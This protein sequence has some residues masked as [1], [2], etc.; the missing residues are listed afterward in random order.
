MDDTTTAERLHG[1]T[2]AALRDQP[3]VFRADLL[4][5]RRILVTGAG[6]GL[7]KAI[8]TLCARLGADLAICGRDRGRLDASAAFLEQFGTRIL[9]RLVSIR[10]PDAV[11]NFLDEAW[12]ALGPLDGVV[13]NAGGQFP[14]A[15]LD[16]TR[17]GWNAVIDTNLNGT[18]WV[19]QDVARRWVGASQ[20]GSIVNIVADF[21]RGMPGIAHTCAARAAV[22]YLSKT[23]AVEWAPHGIRVNCVAPGCV[24]SEGF[25]H[26]PPA[27]AATYWE[28]N[29]QLRPGD[30]W[31]IAEACVYLLA[32]SGKFITGEVITVDGGQ[33]LWGDPWPT[34]RPEWFRLG[35]AP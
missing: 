11:A 30:P 5:G 9:A 27:G 1:M 17:N 25:A 16:F 14:Q 35:G 6:R 33:Q 19:M 10:D 32:A 8:A 31:D 4:Q 21:W 22:A 34:G 13:N 18:W 2:D 29:P 20:P 28:A 3:S 7:G 26:Y 23:L 15:A 24:E 12:Q